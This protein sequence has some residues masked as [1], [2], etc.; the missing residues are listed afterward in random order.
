MIINVIYFVKLCC[1]LALHNA[2]LELVEG[3]YQLQVHQLVG[4]LDQ[5]QD[6]LCYI[7]LWCGLVCCGVMCCIQKCQTN[8]TLIEVICLSLQGCNCCDNFAPWI[9]MACQLSAQCHA[10]TW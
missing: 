7:V 6:N 9:I 3:G 10:T 8:C 2:L 5:L 1:D 4:D